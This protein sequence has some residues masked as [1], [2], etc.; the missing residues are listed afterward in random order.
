MTG[1]N[2]SRGAGNS[3]VNNPLFGQP[4]QPQFITFERV[5]ED[6]G[7]RRSAHVSFI[8]LPGGAAAWRGLIPACMLL[9]IIT[10]L[11]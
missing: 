10:I 8:P 5:I 4:G 3:A 2:I 11:R 9:L 1:S 6:H 7:A